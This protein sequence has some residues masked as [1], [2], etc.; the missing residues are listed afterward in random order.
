MGST[1]RRNAWLSAALLCV[2]M[3]ILPVLG[4][5]LFPKPSAPP[6]GP[7]P[8]AS[9]TLASAPAAPAPSSSPRRTEDHEA[10][11][12][13]DRSASEG[14]SSAPITGTVLDPDGK[15]TGGAIVS[16]DDPD[17]PMNANT[18]EDGRFELPPEA[19][20][21]DATAR[22]PVFRPS[23]RVRLSSGGRN[24]LRL[25]RG[26]A[27]EGAVVDDRGS[28]VSS[29]LV[30]IESFQP[31]GDV[32]ASPPG[33]RAKS[34]ADAAGEFRFDD[35]PAGRYV[36]T[37]SAPGMPPTRSSSIDVELGAT[38]R[39]V[40]ITLARGATLFGTIVDAET[41]RPITSAKVALDSATS[42]GANAIGASTSDAGG[43]YALEGV[44]PGPFSVRVSAEG[45]RVK[46]VSG[47]TTRGAPKVREDIALT[48]RGD[49]GSGES[50]LVG[51]G[52][53]LVPSSG[54]VKIAT[55]VEGGPAEKS[56]VKRGD[57][58]ARIDGAD[59]SGM[60]VSDCVQ[61][62]RGPEGTRVSITLR[63]DESAD[64]EVTVV[65][66]TIVR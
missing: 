35:L 32:G 22:H 6:R 17:K 27:I 26:G 42:S 25:S 15:P 58:I 62:L 43:A 31:A 3:L 18:G 2:A 16:C 40:R 33:G 4:W 13:P 46:I 56:G 30:A 51:I 44:P 29:Y 19:A 36:L 34:V 10:P 59:A 9:A 52:A 64:V 60:S 37:A 12:A 20:G 63:R 8:R 54:G 14:A 53:V 65:R 11:R 57:L 38:A 7:S 41:R 66:A 45:Y 5:I 23:E 24:T 48:P 47:L 50:E 61:R 49:A 28:P 1:S 21:C 39:G 55:L